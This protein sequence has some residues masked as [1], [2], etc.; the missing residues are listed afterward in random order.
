MVFKDTRI[1]T[2]DATDFET[3]GAIADT[4]VKAYPSM[5]A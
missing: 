5:V 4:T 2:M 1:Y 3:V